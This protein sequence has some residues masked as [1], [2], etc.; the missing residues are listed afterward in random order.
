VKAGQKLGTVE[1]LVSGKSVGTSPLVTKRGY[2]EAS[3]W[4]K[5]R[6]WSSGLAMRV[7]RWISDLIPS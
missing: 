7:S 4:Q 3:L 2:E 5:V 1:V 6:Y